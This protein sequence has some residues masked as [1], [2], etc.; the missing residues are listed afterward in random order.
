MSRFEHPRWLLL[1][2][3]L[4]SFFAASCGEAGQ[5][6]AADLTRVK[7]TLHRST[8]EVGCPE[9]TVTIHGDGRVV[10]RTEP[11]PG[12]LQAVLL[13]GTHEDQI[14]PE[15]VAALF[16]QFQKAGFFK[17]RSA[18]QS[19]WT[20]LST[21]VLTV[22]TGQR[23]K[24]VTESW[25]EKVGMPKIVTKLEEDVDKA[26]GTDRW[27][28]GSTGVIAWLEGQHFDFH[29]PEAA[30]LAALG[31]SRR[32]DEAMVLAM[33]DR[34][35]PLDSVVSIRKWGAITLAPTPVVAGFSM[36]E[37]AIRRGQAGLF[38][39][40]AAAGWIDGMGREQAA[41]L[42]A[43]YGA[44]C[45]PALV[46]AAADTGIDID[47]PEPPHPNPPIYYPQGKTALANLAT[48]PCW[49]H[50][51][52]RVAAAQRLLARGAN[53]NHRDSFGHTPLFWAHDGFGI[54]GM[55][56][57]LLAHGAERR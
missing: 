28:R 25:G 27:L 30:Q 45:S 57:L 42:F 48:D 14:A 52:D 7:I 38:S 10:F 36:M 19:N 6:P 3:V 55:V 56:N 15:K 12:P 2:L 24:S 40:L 44:G 16:A 46:D 5:L 11:V 41:Q 20:D 37:S 23:Q 50:K 32:A 4:G 39:K 22:D 31:A 49:D 53:P 47:E 51:E 29:S 33:I 1:S 8:C 17:L 43:Q 13:P 34:G 54:P 21:H 9:Y 26:A 18:Y 35:V